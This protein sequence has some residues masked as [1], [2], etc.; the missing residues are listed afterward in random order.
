MQQATLSRGFY[1][2]FALQVELEKERKS[3]DVH[4]NSELAKLAIEMGFSQSAVRNTIQK[5][6]ISHHCILFSIVDICIFEL[7]LYA[8]ASVVKGL[9]NTSR[10]TCF[11]D[12]IF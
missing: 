9:Q 11:H 8:K 6:V 2:F 3:L 5:Y 1:W 12:V 10:K 7:F 4:M